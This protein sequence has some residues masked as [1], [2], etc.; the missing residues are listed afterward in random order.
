[1]KD[2]S[3]KASRETIERTIKALT[4]NGIEAVLAAGGDEARDKV[5]SWIP[6]GAEV[7]TAASTTLDMLGLAKEL[8]ESGRFDSVKARLMAMDQKT[9]GREMRKLG[10]G[11]DIALGSAHAVTETGV[12]LAASLTGSQLPAYAYGAG[13]LIWVVG[14]QKIVKDLAE[15]FKRIEEYVLPLES[16]RARKAYGL[17]D[18]FSSFPAKILVFNREIQP[19]RVKLVF[20]DE[21][22]GF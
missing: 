21:A 4:A 20:V 14:V 6:A 17:P 18:S 16:A 1:M 7:F 13:A 2:F 12:V 22:I 3:A 15:G 5:L 19:G 9:Q 11:P 8:N 10:A